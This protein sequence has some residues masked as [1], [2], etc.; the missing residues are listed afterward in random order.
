MDAKISMEFL[1]SQMNKFCKGVPEENSECKNIMNTFNTSFNQLENKLES[2]AGFCSVIGYCQSGEDMATM[3]EMMRNVF[4]NMGSLLPSL[5]FG[6]GGNPLD[7]TSQCS[8]CSDCM[9]NIKN[10]LKNVTT[11]GMPDE[12]ITPMLKD[13]FAIYC[14]SMKK[15]DV[16]EKVCKRIYNGMESIQRTIVSSS[17]TSSS[18]STTTES[19]TEE[20]AADEFGLCKH[21]DMC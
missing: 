6:M 4:D 12:D 16:V 15:G 2:R 9:K 8:F 10:T 13:G 7:M 18:Q 14:R 3:K 19:P 20:T 21:F 17:S 11:S 5:G 1:I